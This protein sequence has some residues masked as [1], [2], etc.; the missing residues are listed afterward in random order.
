MNNNLFH[1]FNN[2]FRGKNE[3]QHELFGK[4]HFA[5]KYKVKCSFFRKFHILQ[6]IYV[7]F[8]NLTRSKDIFGFK[9]NKKAF[10]NISFSKYSLH[11]LL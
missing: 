1:N 6:C 5:A 10:E 9:W 8:F 7:Y 4:V 11:R 2:L 3:I